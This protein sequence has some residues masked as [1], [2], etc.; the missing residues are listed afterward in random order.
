MPVACFLGR[1]RI[2]RLMNAPGT[3]VG[4]NLLF[5]VGEQDR[6]TSKEY[7]N[8]NKE[9]HPIGVDFL[10][11]RV[12]DSKI[13]SKLPVAAWSPTARW[14]RNSNFLRSRKCNRIPNSPHRP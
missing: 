9:I 2:H 5:V 4:I 10:F 8:N 13:E 6:V 14:R 12:R 11:S 1:G 3:G 7:T